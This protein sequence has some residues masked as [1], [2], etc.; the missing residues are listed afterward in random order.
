MIT[1]WVITLT[2]T[3]GHEVDGGGGF[4]TVTV[5][6]TEG[7]DRLEVRQTDCANGGRWLV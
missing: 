2:L 4:N 7:A 5:L 1:A 6:G 3:R